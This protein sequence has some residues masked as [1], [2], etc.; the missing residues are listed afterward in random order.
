[1]LLPYARKAALADT[2][3]TLRGLISSTTTGLVDTAAAIRGALVD[4]ANALRTKINANDVAIRSDLADTS[5]TLRGLISSTTTGLIDTAAAIRTTL[6]TK[7]AYADTA[8]MLLPYARKAALAD[9]ASTLR[10]LISSTTTG[11]VDTAA[12]IRGALVDTANALRTKINANDVAIRSD[13]ADT[14]ST[15]RGLISSTTTGL[16]DTAAAIRTTLNTKVAYA[17][18]ANILLPYARKAALADTA[19]TLRGLISST[20][21]GLIDTAA[22]IRTTLNTKVAYADTANML[23]PYARKAA[24]ADTAST[25]RG[26]ISSTTTGLIDTAAAIRGALVDT[27]NALRTKI[28]A[29]DVA[30]RSDL[31]DT[32]STLRGLISSTT[33]GLIDT[34]A[35]IRTTLNTKVAYADTANMLLP[36]ARKAA[37]ADTASTLRGLISS[38]TTGLVDT[39][40]AIRGALVDTAN[41]LRTK[42]NANDVAIRSDLADT[43]STLRGL[44]SS[45]TTGLIDTAA[46]IRTT[47]NTKVAYADTANMLLPY[48]RKA[49]LA[50]TASTLRGLISSTTTGLVDT[51]AAIRGALV[52]SANALR[53]KINANDVAIRSDLADTSSTLRGLISSTTTG[54]IDT[55]AAI[56]TTLNTKVAYADTANMLLPYAR[57]AA[58]ADTASTLRGLISSTTTGLVD[59]AAAIRG[60]LVDTANALRTKINANDVAIRSD[61]A[62][63][64][65]TLRGLISS[66]TT[67][68]I[69]TAAAIRTT[70]NTKVAYADTANMLL[71]YARK[72]ALADTA[73]TL[74]GLISSTTSGLIDT[75]A[76]IR[77]TLNTKVAYADTANMLLPY[78][79]KAALADTASTLRGLISSTTTGLVDTAAAIRGALVDTANALRTKINAN[80]VAIRSD[81]ADTSSTLRG[82]ISSTTTG[83]IDTAASIRT[84]LNTKVAYA[85]TANMLLPYA[86]KAALADTASTLRSLISSTTTGLIDTAAAIRT[87]LNTKVA[88]ADTANMLLPYARKAALADTASTLR[89]LISSTS[90]GLIDTAA[91]IRGA[92]V[93][94]ANALRTKIN[95]NDVAIRSDLADTSS[96]LR[97]LISSTTS[98]LIDTAA[99]IR[100]TLNT[101]VA[102]ADTANM[103]LPYARKAALADTASTLRGLISSTTT[104]LVD[105]AA[106]IR[107]ALVDT[108][109][110]LRTKINA[111]DV[112]IRSDL[113]D[114]SSTLRGLISST[115]TGLI[116]TAAAIRGALV[117]T[118]N[119][120]RTKINANDV[121]I[122]SDLADTSST[123]R[124]LISSTTTGLIDTAAAIRTTLNT[125]VAYADTANMLLPYARKAA[126]ADT[127]STLRGLISS[128][129]TGLI[130]TAAAIRTTLNTKVAYADTANMLLPYARKAALA[131]TASTL[132]GLISS[133]TTGLVDTAAAIRGALVDTAN[134]LRTKINANDVAIRSDLADTSSTLRGLI[135]STTTGLIDTAAAIRTTLNT[136][137]AYADTANMLLPYARKAALADTAST[138]RGLISSTTTGLIDTAAAIRTTLNTKVAYA[139]TANML[140]PY[141]RK[142]ALTD[143][144]S[145]LRGLISSTTT[146]LVD[147][148]AAIRTTL[149]TKVAYADT[150]NMLLPYARKAALADTASTLRG[151]ISS[152]STG[153]ID[154][155]A[156]IRTTLNTK[157]AYADTANM[158]LPYARKAALADTASTLR[159]LISSTTTGL[160]DT[161]AAI[162]TTLNSKVAYADTANML[163]PYARK[164]ALADTASTL[165]GLISSTTTG[166]IDTAAAIRTTLNTKVAYADTAN[167]LL[168]YARKAALADTAST[169]RGLISSTT[170]GLIDTAAA[171]RGALVDTANALRSTIN[172]HIASDYDKDTT[173]ERISSMTYANDTLKIVEGSQTREVKIP[174]YIKAMG[175]ISSTGT[176]LKIMGATVSRINKGDYQITFTSPM[177][178]ADYIIQL[179][180]KDMNGAGNDSPSITY[181]SQT[182]SGFII[183]TA[184][185]DNGST[186]S[187]DEDME[188]MFSVLDF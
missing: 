85:D 2:A 52:D 142:A 43:S 65:S 70:L 138:L 179:S 8:N 113:A 87:T 164:A 98:G 134:A 120:L 114:T 42:I 156:A 176:A 5:S 47:L 51:A 58:L 27:A 184:D 150:A 170:T 66:T 140:L 115:T 53:T 100:T 55:A 130:D 153:L 69:D 84:T 9:T 54:L 160:I 83:L 73:S 149:N 10:G 121:A 152:T 107:G 1:M 181:T 102:Y 59:T 110:A 17:D 68:L 19:S 80:D 97:G 131:D 157:V 39:A 188:F 86:R 76:A 111:N 21:S 88:Y 71:P 15:L 49:A 82:L 74:R 26:L 180:V 129:T 23:L 141:A 56:R 37:L 104:G 112:A 108:A 178:S 79:R 151:L 161:A 35:A 169:L 12:A 126:L 40:A 13:L 77:T 144:A 143:T 57:K 127:A 62:D 148:A 94:T 139:D 48:A 105:T 30:I 163:L 72:A 63:T 101:K 103:L 128:T 38:T 187:A 78:A 177:P 16:I 147:T 89:G 174:A 3:S 119:A 61:L 182:T 64:S 185:N 171:I 122:R 158:L 109:N 132:R 28:N 159:G 41:A 165:R 50:D 172:A 154:T 91:A 93:D 133:T 45:T 44:I 34:A 167:M 166:L 118:A 25:L 186:D 145:T 7:V 124:G 11:L 123:L 31:A 136:K 36:Y 60:A 24:L 125:K 92:L 183:K 116:D 146:G 90:T 155:A 22:A 4:T 137:V 162:R 99:A 18:T 95:A 6:N 175:K 46:A 106:A 173:N 135:S 33:T 29:N 168:P 81:L 96:T 75:A 14:S 32:S 67:G 117:D 20:T